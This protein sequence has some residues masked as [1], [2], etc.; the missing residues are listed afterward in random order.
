MQSFFIG[1]LYFFERDYFAFSTKFYCFSLYFVLL[2]SQIMGVNHQIQDPFAFIGSKETP[3]SLEDFGFF[4]DVIVNLLNWMYP[5]STYA[6]IPSKFL[7]PYLDRFSAMVSFYGNAQELTEYG[8]LLYAE[9]DYKFLL[10]HPILK[11]DP[12]KVYDP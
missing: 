3:I 11:K 12:D 5:M 10:E 9:L 8:A 7:G 2:N 6:V 1:V 4:W